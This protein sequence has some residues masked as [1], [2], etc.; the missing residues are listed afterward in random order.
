MLTCDDSETDPRVDKEACRLVGLR[1]MIVVPLRHEAEVVGVLKVFSPDPRNFDDAD[2][3]ILGLMSDLIASAMFNATQ[4]ESGALFYRATHDA[5]AGLANRAL[6][7]DR[8]RH[9]LDN[10]RRD[11]RSFAL[12]SLD[13]DGLKSINDTLGHGAGDAALCEIAE[14]LEHNSRQGD[15]V[16]RAGGD[17]FGVILAQSG[18]PTNVEFHA[19]HIDERLRAPF[20]FESHPVPLAASIGTAICPEQGEDMIQL[21]DCADQSMYAVK[22]RRSG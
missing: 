11:Q 8:L 12:L 14:R 15:T 5:L 1:S 19:S 7:Y 18:G 16:A 4:N 10:A 17:E 6:F 20:H 21:I 3:E 2:M 13:M 22:R 9:T